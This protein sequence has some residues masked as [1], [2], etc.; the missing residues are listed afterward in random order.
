VAGSIPSWTSSGAKALIEFQVDS[1]EIQTVQN[2]S[3]TETNSVLLSVNPVTAFSPGYPLFVPSS[4]PVELGPDGS[5]FDRGVVLCLVP[6]LGEPDDE[7]QLY[8][9][10]PALDRWLSCEEQGAASCEPVEEFEPDGLICASV[11]DRGM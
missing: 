11:T 4:T 3:V 9:Y 10:D 1:D 2:E 7:I 5:E 8:S 6:E